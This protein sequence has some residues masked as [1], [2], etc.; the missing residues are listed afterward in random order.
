[1]KNVYQCKATR[2][3]C[4]TDVKK[5]VNIALERKWF[6]SN[7]NS[8]WIC[9]IKGAVTGYESIEIKSE[10]IVRTQRTGWHACA[11]TKGSWDT[12]FI[13]PREMKKVW[14]WVEKVENE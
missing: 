2:T 8:W 12:L 4:L 14:E 10:N 5:E 6:A 13:T 3:D 1:M 11:G 7:L 9:I